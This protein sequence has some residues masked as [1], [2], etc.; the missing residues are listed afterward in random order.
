MHEKSVLTDIDICT[1]T[2]F[3]DSSEWEK[4][5]KWTC[6]DDLDRHPCHGVDVPDLRLGL[7]HADARDYH[8]DVSPGCCLAVASQAGLDS[9]YDLHC[10]VADCHAYVRSFP[11]L[12]V[13]VSHPLF[14]TL[15]CTQNYSW[16]Q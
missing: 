7:V 3:N 15:R 16:P 1:V 5:W 9:A 8:H 13:H 6:V 11:C 10:V 14:A 12:S 4:L 2:N